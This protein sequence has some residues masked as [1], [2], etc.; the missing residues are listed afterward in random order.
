MRRLEQQPAADLAHRLVAGGRDLRERRDLGRPQRPLGDGLGC[1]AAGT[2]PA[3]DAAVR[4]ASS[5]GTAYER[6]I[7][8]PSPAG[9]RLLGRR[10]TRAAPR[11][12]SLRAPARAASSACS[13]ATSAA[14]RGARAELARAAAAAGSGELGER[15]ARRPRR[16]ASQPRGR[17]CAASVVRPEPAWPDELDLER[18]P[19]ALAG[20]GLDEADDV[21]DLLRRAAA[22]SSGSRTAGPAARARAT[23]P[24]PAGGRGRAG[25]RSSPSSWRAGRRLRR[26]GARVAQRTSGRVA[27]EAR[28]RR[29]VPRD[30][31]RGP[32]SH[33]AVSSRPGRSRRRAA[34]PARA[35][36]RVRARAA[37]AR[38]GDELELGAER[39]PAGILAAAR[40]A[41]PSGAG[42]ARRPPQNSA[43]A[44]RARSRGSSA[45]STSLWVIARLSSPTYRFRAHSSR[46]HSTRRSA[47][48]RTSTSQRRLGREARG[49]TT[50]TAWSPSTDV[51]CR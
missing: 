47:R 4:A 27:A 45:S 8:A 30:R 40:R 28:R 25:R 36:P 15:C 22:G 42:R 46:H 7:A 11:R 10:G 12:E 41:R 14:R 20:H 51:G 38:A 16:A 29:P 1:R 13:P 49:T 19:A 37:P 2:A 39:R 43:P 5:G 33:R 18:A 24:R 3:R 23:G 6:R 32:A 17:A 44:S 26:P 9:G 34:A 35:R 21:V 31:P 48:S 50:L